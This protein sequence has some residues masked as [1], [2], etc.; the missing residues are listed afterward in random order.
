MGH[1]SVFLKIILQLSSKNY[2]A[3]KKRE[4]VNQAIAVVFRFLSLYNI[5]RTYS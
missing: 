2:W 1:F 5:T 3:L 4:I